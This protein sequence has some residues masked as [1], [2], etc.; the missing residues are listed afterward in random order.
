MKP[1]GFKFGAWEVRLSFGTTEEMGKLTRLDS[2]RRE[3]LGLRGRDPGYRPA[4]SWSFSA[5]VRPEYDLVAM[6]KIEP[7]VTG[8][9]HDQLGML[10]AAVGVP[11]SKLLHPVEVTEAGVTIINW[12]WR[13]N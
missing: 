7:G 3:Q 2:E 9:A 1:V 6:S 4:P 11:K 12:Q 10:A 5:R 8:A 13:D